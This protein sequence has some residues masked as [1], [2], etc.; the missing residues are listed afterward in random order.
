MNQIQID[1]T[2]NGNHSDEK[3]KTIN[4]E[5]K[6]LKKELEKITKNFNVISS[7]NQKKRNQINALRKERTL[8]DHIFKTL[9]Y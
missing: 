4:K 5:L 7:A 1:Q 6:S 3:K 8:Y 2:Q 9:E